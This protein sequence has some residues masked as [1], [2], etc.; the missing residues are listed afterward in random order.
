MIDIVGILGVMQKSFL[1]GELRLQAIVYSI[2]RQCD[3]PFNNIIDV[4]TRP[5]PL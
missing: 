5:T 2:G 3:E 4:S 1:I